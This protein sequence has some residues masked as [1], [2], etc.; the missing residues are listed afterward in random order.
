MDD[1]DDDA[2]MPHGLLVVMLDVL[3]AM[4]V[5]GLVVQR[6]RKG[7]ENRE[8]K[9]EGSGV[10]GYENRQEEREEVKGGRSHVHGT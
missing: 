7:D 9:M 6:E 8:T 1:E 3:M 5:R 10:F 2:S 4:V